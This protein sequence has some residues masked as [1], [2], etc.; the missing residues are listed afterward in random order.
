MGAEGERCGIKKDRPRYR[1]SNMISVLVAL[2]TLRVALAICTQSFFQPDE[3]Y[4]SLEPAH[5]LVF[6]YG[7]LTWEWLAEQPLRSPIYPALN[8]PIYWL[9]RVTKLH[10][11]LPIS[12]VSALNCLAAPIHLCSYQVIGP[13]ILHG[14]FAAATDIWLRDLATSIIGK[15]YASTAVSSTVSVTQIALNYLFRSFCRQLRFS[16]H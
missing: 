3:Y 7:H 16:T 9:L 14:L 15:P 8:V 11:L 2:I 12:V 6:G 5:I 10:E 1:N 13:R 4:Q